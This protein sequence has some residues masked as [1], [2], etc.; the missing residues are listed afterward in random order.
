MPKGVFSLATAGHACAE[1]K[2]LQNPDVDGVSIRQDLADLEP[3]EAAFDWSFLDSEV[4]RAAAAD[5]KF[6]FASTPRPPNQLGLRPPSLKLGAPFTPFWKTTSGDHHPRL[7]GPDFSREEKG[8]DYGP[9]CPYSPTILPLLSSGPVS[10]MPTVKIG[11]CRT[12]RPISKPAC[13]RLHDGQV[14]GR[15]KA[16][17]RHDDGRLPQTIRYACDR[18]KRWSRSRPRLCGPERHSRR[19]HYLARRFIVQKK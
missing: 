16:D 10:P 19:P 3:S 18:G 6:F 15:R 5:K 7:L 1:K 2:V 14:A 8:D 11:A 4:S 13:G 17:H 9:R 12:R